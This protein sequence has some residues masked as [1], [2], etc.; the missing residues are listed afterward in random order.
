MGAE[1]LTLADFKVFESKINDNLEA[2]KSNQLDILKRLNCLSY[3]DLGAPSQTG[4]ITAQEFMKAVHI[5]R[6]KFNQLI[7]D[8]K[9]KT[10]KKSRRIYV[11]VSEVDRFFTDPSVR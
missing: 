3:T 11:P 9:I 7:F 4:Y 1:I 10:I 5:R 6:W 8:N 2:I